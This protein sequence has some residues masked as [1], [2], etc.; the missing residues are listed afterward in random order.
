MKNITL[1]VEE[2]VLA[3]VRRFAAESGTT[4]N[5]LVREHLAR[6]AAQADEARRERSHRELMELIDSVQGGVGPI[7]WTR[8][9]LHS[10][11]R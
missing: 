10:R 7:T 2:D 4:V 9:E 11:G 8:D 1:A 3:Q 6:I 5:A